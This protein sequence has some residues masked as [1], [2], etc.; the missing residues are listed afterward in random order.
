MKRPLLLIAVLVVIFSAYEIFSAVLASQTTGT[1][2]VDVLTPSATITLRQTGHQSANIGVGHAKIRLRPGSYQLI[3]TSGKLQTVKTVEIS[4]NQTTV[5]TIQLLTPEQAQQAQNIAEAN[6]LIKFLPYTGRAYDY[7]VDYSYQFSGNLSQPLI[8]VTAP[9]AAGQEAAL[10]WIS[11]FKID[12]SK[13][14]IKYVSAPL[15]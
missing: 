13:L 7:R 3:A 14:N 2:K 12:P 11:S 4:K 5:E 6:K 15:N 9:T 8:T 10:N 1:L